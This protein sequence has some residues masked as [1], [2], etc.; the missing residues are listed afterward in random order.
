MEGGEKHE[1]KGSLKRRSDR[2]SLI[3]LLSHCKHFTRPWTDQL[4]TQWLLPGSGDKFPFLIIRL[5]KSCSTWQRFPGCSYARVARSDEDICYLRSLSPETGCLRPLSANSPSK[6]T[7]MREV[8]DIFTLPAGNR[9]EV[10]LQ[11]SFS[12]RDFFCRYCWLSA[13]NFMPN[14]NEGVS[15]EQ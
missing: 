2:G 10:N 3:S 8:Y 12:G 5:S 11:V 6:S 13:W 1:N 4:E 15:S 7:R 9:R 14:A